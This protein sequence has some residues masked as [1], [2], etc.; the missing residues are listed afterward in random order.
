MRSPLKFHYQT[1]LVT[2]AKIYHVYYFVDAP[3]P[4]IKGQTLMN[5]Q[6]L[7]KCNRMRSQNVKSLYSSNSIF[8]LP[9]FTSPFDCLF[10]KL[11]DRNS[12][13]SRVVI[14]LLRGCC[15]KLFSVAADFLNFV[16]YS[17]AIFSKDTLLRR[18]CAKRSKYLLCHYERANS[19]I[20]CIRGLWT[21]AAK[22]RC[23]KPTN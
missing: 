17:Q 21:L 11:F 13:V 3:I 1:Q 9:H 2:F 7:Q 22:W 18:L 15:S 10:P 14:W 4:L 8:L 23:K 20:W 6:T 5:W 19:C 12:L 16:T